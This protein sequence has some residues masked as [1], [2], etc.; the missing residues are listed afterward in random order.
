M[1]KRWIKVP[2]PGEFRG[3]GKWFEFDK[4]KDIQELSETDREHT[5]KYYTSTGFLPVQVCEEKPE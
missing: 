4:F 3:E 5:W 2:G 1:T